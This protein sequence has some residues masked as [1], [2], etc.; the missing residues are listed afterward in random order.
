MYTPSDFKITDPGVI[1]K[2]IKENSFGIL[3][4]SVD[5]SKIQE[6]HTPL[7]L[8]E[9]GNF[10][11]GHLARANSHWRD[12][13]KNPQVKIIFHGPHCYVSPSFYTSDFN[14]PTWN[15]TAVSIEGIVE[16]IQSITEQR[17]FMRQ[18]VEENEAAF[19]SPWNLDEADERFIKLFSAVV[20]FKVRIDHLEAKFKLNQN[21]SE[22]DRLGVIKRLEAS[23]SS[24]EQAV[25]QL[26]K[27]DLT[28][29]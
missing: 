20:F 16:I 27:A 6:T 3:V 29:D 22:E 8:S 25:A 12:W 28:Q 9:D 24:F 21:K 15:Y 2:F 4:S 13:E 17:E 5:G 19:P 11:L 23:N 7:L 26:M 1:R 18:L 14:V 10:V